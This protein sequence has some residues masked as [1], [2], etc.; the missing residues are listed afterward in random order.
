LMLQSRAEAWSASD[1]EVTAG[2]LRE[3]IG[4][5]ERASAGRVRLETVLADVPA[6][7]ASSRCD[8]IS[9]ASS[10]ALYFEDGTSSDLVARSGCALG[11]P[12]P[13]GSRGGPGACL[14]VLLLGR[15]VAARRRAAAAS[16]E[17]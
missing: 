3:R 8:D 10:A 7:D 1:C 2:S 16:A 13:R 6:L 15:R 12:S 5:F 14:V 11:H 9:R 4:A 17:L